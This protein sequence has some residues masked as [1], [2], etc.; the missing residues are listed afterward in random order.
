MNTNLMNKSIKTCIKTLEGW[1]YTTDSYEPDTI[2]ACFNAAGVCIRWK[3][4][5]FSPKGRCIRIEE[6]KW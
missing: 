3:K 2:E 1:G 5:Y 4:L 6:H